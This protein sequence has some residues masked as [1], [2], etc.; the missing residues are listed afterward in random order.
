M[1]AVLEQTGQV[2]SDYLHVPKVVRPGSMLVLDEGVLK[3]YEIAPADAAV[4]TGVRE[5]AYEAVC[6]ASRSG[7]LE[8]TGDLGFVILHRCGQGF[9]FLLVSTW[10]NDNELWET[11]WAKDGADAPAFEPWPADGPHRPTF[12]VWEL[13]AVCH[14]RRAWSRYLRSRRDSSARRE[15]LLDT[16]SGE[17]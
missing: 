4:P 14:E 15:Y 16:F 3:W 2:R 10:R 7:E 8:L 9:Y 5:L 13:G 17:V 1:S 11:V 6:R 12:C